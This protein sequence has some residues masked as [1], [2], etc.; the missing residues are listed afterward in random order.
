MERIKG[1]I[2]SILERRGI[3]GAENAIAAREL[4]Q[5]LKKSER[6]MRSDIT[7][8]RRSGAPI[9]SHTG[10]IHGYYLPAGG[11]QGVEEIADYSKRQRMR[12]IRAF[13]LGGKVNSVLRAIAS[14]DQLAI[15]E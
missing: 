5:I 11:E 10:R 13:S 6:T 12:G 4:A 9:L 8:E 15:E 1:N 2:E 14:K 7:D 3:Y